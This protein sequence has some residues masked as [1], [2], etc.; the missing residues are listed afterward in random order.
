MTWKRGPRWA[1]HV[2]SRRFWRKVEKTETCWLWI[3]PVFSRPDRA[4]YGSFFDGQRNRLAHR[5]SWELLHGPVPTGMVVRHSCSR[6]L[7]VNPEHLSVGT[8]EDNTADRVE[9]IRNGRIALPVERTQVELW[10]GS[11]SIL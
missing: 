9:A 8:H 10:P 6:R 3:G 4:A 11:D 2:L 1:P 5:V 7:C